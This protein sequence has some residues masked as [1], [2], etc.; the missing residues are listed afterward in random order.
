MPA[1]P[2]IFIGYI[3]D[4]ELMIHLNRSKKWKEANLTRNFSLSEVTYQS[5]NYIG[6]F[7]PS[8]INYDQ[9]KRKEQELKLQMQIYCPKFNLDKQ[10]VYLFLQLFLF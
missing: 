8:L 9:L 1:Q 3:Q 7:I 10:P 5:K 4:K 2:R 6:F